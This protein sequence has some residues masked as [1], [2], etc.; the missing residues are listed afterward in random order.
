MKLMVR[1]KIFES[2]EASVGRRDNR[3]H[4]PHRKAK[5]GAEYVFARFGQKET[6]LL[7]SARIN[8]LVSKMAHLVERSNNRFRERIVDFTLEPDDFL[9]E[10]EK[11]QMDLEGKI[12][13]PAL[14]LSDPGIRQSFERNLATT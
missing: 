4:V 5:G 11:R 12:S 3:A 7:T 14:D 13:C 1:T 2:Y 6:E 8:Q 9:T 10:D